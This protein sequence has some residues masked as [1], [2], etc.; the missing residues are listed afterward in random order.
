MRR[1]KLHEIGPVCG[2]IDFR[3]S[4]IS[5]VIGFGTS[6]DPGFFHY[7][8]V[9]DVY[10]RAQLCSRAQASVRTQY[11][12]LEAEQG[13]TLAAQ[14]LQLAGNVPVALLA[15]KSADAQLARMDT[16][17][18]LPLRKALAADIDR[19]EKLAPTDVVGLSLRMEKVLG[20]IDAL[21]LQ[22][23]SKEPARAD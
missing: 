14:Q 3:I 21:A 11:V 4:D 18:Y 15:L 13:L 10:F 7:N 22:N 6:A 23:G 20:G 1:S 9:P 5:E 8:E 19:L 17:E 12:L 2:L 16:A